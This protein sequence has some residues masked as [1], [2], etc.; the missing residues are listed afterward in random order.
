MPRTIV[1]A[2]IIGSISL[3]LGC[4]GERTFKRL[5]QITDQ[6]R[7]TIDDTLIRTYDVSLEQA[8]EL[9]KDSGWQIKKRGS[10]VAEARVQGETIA[11]DFVRIE[12]WAPRGEATAI[13]VRYSREG[14]RVESAKILDKLEAILPGKR[15]IAN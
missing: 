7:W 10:E 11:G 6:G 14:D 2:L 12:I 13:G 1:I 15:I 5:E 8:V 3:A 9:F 4:S